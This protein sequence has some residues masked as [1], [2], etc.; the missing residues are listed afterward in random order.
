MKTLISVEIVERVYS[1]LC[2]HKNVLSRLNRASEK[3]SLKSHR[4]RG[5][6]FSG[7]DK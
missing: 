2:R 7:K 3:W 1:R 5:K 4:Q 6:I